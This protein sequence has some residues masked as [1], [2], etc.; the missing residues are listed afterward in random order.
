MEIID[1]GLLRY[2]EAAELQYAMVEAVSGGAEDRL[3]LLEHHPVITFGRHGGEEFLLAG[4]QYLRERGIDLV[5]S[6]RGGKITCHYP[7]QLVAYPIINIARWN[8]SACALPQRGLHGLYYGME[9]AVIRCARSF[10]LEAA[11]RE[12]F[13]GAWTM[14]MGKICSIGTAVRRGV[15]YHGLAL[16]VAADTSLFDLITLCGLPDAAPASLSG[17]L[18]RVITVQE[19]KDVFRSHFIE[20][21]V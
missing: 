8:K 19:V 5:K 21:F 15:T 3:L 1:L 9:E 13:P 20:L 7:G 2:A 17:E 6:T 11:R 12:G 16:N 18:G 4:E 10:G 14:A